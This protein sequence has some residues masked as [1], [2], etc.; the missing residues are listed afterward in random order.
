M[1]YFSVI[2]ILRRIFMQDKILDLLKRRNK[3]LSIDDFQHELKLS[4]EEQIK[5]L[6]IN[7][8]N[9]EKQYQIYHTNKDRYMLYDN[10]RLKVGKMIANKKGFG[11]VD[12]DD[13]EDI[14][15][16]YTN[17]NGALNGDKVIVEITSKKGLKLEGRV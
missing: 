2:I 7:L 3:A 11:F 14:Y 16:A 5:E 17:M 10:S 13:D 15:V 1:P 9:L 12:V 8:D 4:S 6:L